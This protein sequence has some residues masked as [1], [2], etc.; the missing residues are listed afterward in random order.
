MKAKSS[1]GLGPVKRTILVAALSVAAAG[2]A[3]A[4][5]H[6]SLVRSGASCPVGGGSP[7]E[8]E[9]LRVKAMKPLAGPTK[10][11]SRNAGDLVI[12]STTGAELAE[13]EEARGSRCA[14]ELAGAVVRC[15]RADGEILG[16]FDLDHRLVG[17]DEVRY[18]LSAENGA[19]A[20]DERLTSARTAYGSDPTRRWGEARAAFLGAPLRQAGFAYRFSDL[21]VDVTVT[22]LDEGGQGIVLRVQHRAVPNESKGS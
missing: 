1:S 9:A 14:T 15:E 20:I 8:A 13:R 5:A 3:F 6:G 19:A 4:L 11:P 17:I 2:F 21:A 16:R 22:K 18:G 12:G 7:A 10:A